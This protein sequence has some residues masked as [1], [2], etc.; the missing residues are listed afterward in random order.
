[1][2]EAELEFSE[3]RRDSEP[4]NKQIPKFTGEIIG[5]ITYDPVNKDLKIIPD[6]K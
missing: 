6:E 2:R 5:T 3:I 1:M 4:I